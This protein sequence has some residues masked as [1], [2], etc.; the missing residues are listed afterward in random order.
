MAQLQYKDKGDTNRVQH[1]LQTLLQAENQA[2]ALTEE[3]KAALDKLKTPHDLSPKKVTPET[4]S[5]DNGKGKQRAVSEDPQDDTTSDSDEGLG[6]SAV[7]EER[8]RKRGALQSRFRECRLTL[9]R[10]KFFQGDMYHCLG[11]RSAVAEDAAYEAAGEI[12]KELL[13]GL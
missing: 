3:I 6:H 2:L 13:R 1:A 11:E 7:S 10:V 12:R 9:H 5:M 4:S 8:R